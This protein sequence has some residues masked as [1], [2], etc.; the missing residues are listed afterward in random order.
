MPWKF[1][2]CL[3]T[4]QIDW[5]IYK[6][7]ESFIVVCKLSRFSGKF[8]I[9]Y[10]VSRL[11]VNFPDCVKTF[12][13]V[14]KVIRLSEFFS[15]CPKFSR[16]SENFPGRLESFQFVCKLYIMS[17][18]KS[19]LTVNFP[20]F[21]CTFHIVWKVLRVSW[22]FPDCVDTYQNVKQK[23]RLSGNFLIF[24]KV[25]AMC[26]MFLYHLESVPSF[27]QVKRVKRQSEKCLNMDC[28][29]KL[30]KLFIVFL[31]FL[32]WLEFWLNSKVTFIEGILK[33]QCSIDKEI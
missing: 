18:K 33:G 1:Q 22:K 24:Q 13:I 15:D 3:E 12:N 4:F 17:K 25:S 21:L 19:R 26:G 32:V 30:S 9:V 28:F 6:F 29:Q 16:L 27:W 11:S 7:L 14:W 23:F 10:K 5:K 2:D 31:N 8:P 20:D